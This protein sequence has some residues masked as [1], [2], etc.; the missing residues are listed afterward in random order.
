MVS[1][2]NQAA[3]KTE[4][5]DDP[6]SVPSAMGLANTVSIAWEGRSFLDSQHQCRRVCSSLIKLT[7]HEAIEAGSI[8]KFEE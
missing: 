7:S 5:E 1:L 2:R 3:S 4:C 6:I 8:R